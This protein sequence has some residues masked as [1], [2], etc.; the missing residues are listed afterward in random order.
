MKK[1]C[2]ALGTFIGRMGVQL[3]LWALFA[4]ILWNNFIAWEF[5]LPT[6]NYWAFILLRFLIIYFNS[7]LVIK[8]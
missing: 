8:E 1:F 6:F 4:M 2:A 5:N 7:K 3:F